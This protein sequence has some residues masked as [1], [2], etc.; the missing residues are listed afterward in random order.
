MIKGITFDEQDVTAAN[1][2]HVRN[3]FTKGQS[4]FTQGCMVTHD[5]DN[6]YIAS[7]YMMIKG[8]QLQVLGTQTIPHETVSSG[9]LYCLLV[10]QIDLTKTN[11]SISFQQGS[12]ETLTSASGYPAATQQD[13]D[14]GGTLYQWPI[15]QYHVNPNGIDSY[16]IL[17]SSIDMDWMPKKRFSL[18]TVSRTLTIDLR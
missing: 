16:K 17:A 8:R 11:T 18:D 3:L 15:A 2:G 10:Y 5:D 12:V 1:D 4:G 7:G 6:T 14:A 9:E 13:I